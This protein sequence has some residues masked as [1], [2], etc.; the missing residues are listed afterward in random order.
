[1][2]QTIFEADREQTIR[3]I[4]NGSRGEQDT[5]AAVQGFTTQ[6]QFS[7]INICRAVGR[8]LASTPGPGTHLRA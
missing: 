8:L 7:T 5:V 1:M 3:A 6:T 4:A 2:G